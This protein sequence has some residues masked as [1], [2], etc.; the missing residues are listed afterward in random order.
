MHIQTIPPNFVIRTLE[1]VTDDYDSA[2]ECMEKYIPSM[3]VD[4]YGRQV[5]FVTELFLIGGHTSP[6]DLFAIE[7]H[8]KIRLVVTLF[9]DEREK[10]EYEQNYNPTIN[11]TYH[12]HQESQD[13]QRWRSRP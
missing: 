5:P 4:D 12:E 13:S 9:R 1:R 6:E 10:A 11:S 8:S 3:A 7:E 2:F